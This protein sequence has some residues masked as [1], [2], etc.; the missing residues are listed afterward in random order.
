MI[1]ANN[2][3]Y[4][5]S[6]VHIYFNGE[7][8]DTYKLSEKSGLS[9]YTFMG[10]EDWRFST[11]DVLPKGNQNYS[12]IGFD[13]ITINA[14][15]PT[16]TYGEDGNVISRVPYSSG[17]GIFGIDDLCAD[18]SAESIASCSDVVYNASYR[19][20]ND[21]YYAIVGGN[22][23][24]VPALAAMAIEDNVKNGDTVETTMDLLNVNVPYGIA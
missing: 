19:A 15:T 22:K 21:N 16:V 9:S 12:A 4:T 17:E 13:N 24:Y 1:E 8:C 5:D 6:E 11:S 20:P 3:K 10:I 2:E 18:P 14:Y 23:Y 7:Y